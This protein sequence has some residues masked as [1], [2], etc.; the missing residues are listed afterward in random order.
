MNRPGTLASWLAA[1][2][3]VALH[4]G[5][6]SGKATV[7]VTGRLLQDGQP[8]QVSA[9]GLPP[10]SHPIRIVFHAVPGE[11]QPPGESFFCKVDADTGEFSVPGPAGHGIPAGKYRISVAV[12]TAAPAGPG[13]PAASGGR[14]AGPPA[15]GLPPAPGAGAPSPAGVLGTSDRL[16][17]AFSPERTPLEVEITRPSQVILEVGSQPR[18]TVE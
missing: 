17:D 11:G 7:F 12:L 6:Q 10:G 3:L 8:L 1:A 18:A 2:T 9:E 13:G 14:P 4:A 15:G 16:G 5:C